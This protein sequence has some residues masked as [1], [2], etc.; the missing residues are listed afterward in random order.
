MDAEGWRRVL[1]SKQFGNSSSD[2]CKIIGRMTRKLCTAED[3]HESLEAFV[4]CSLTPLDKNP[5]LRPIGIGEIRRRIV[6]KVVVSTVREDITESVGLLQAC[7]GRKAGSEAAVH[8]VHEIFKEQGTEAVLLMDATN[9]FNTVNRKALLHSVKVICPA[10]STYV[11]NWYSLPFRLFVTGSGETTS[12]ECKT[13]GDPTAMAMYTILLEL[14]KKFPNK[15]A[16]MV[17]FADDLSAGG[18]LS[19]IKK[20]WKALCNL[21]PKFGYNPE[22]ANTG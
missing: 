10:V 17:A 15:Q 13:Q 12:E 20:W 7:A 9:G 22:Q 8:A 2:L 3:Q 4:A 5:G 1:T 11:N 18:L 19:N 14:T 6:G 16:K 21:R